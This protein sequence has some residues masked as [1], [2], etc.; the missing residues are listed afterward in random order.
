MESSGIWTTPTIKSQNKILHFEKITINQRFWNIFFQI[1]EMMYWNIFFRQLKY[2]ILML[3]KPV[4]YIKMKL[5]GSSALSCFIWVRM[6]KVEAFWKFS[7]KTF[8][9][10]KT[11]FHPHFLE[12]KQVSFGKFLNLK[13]LYSLRKLGTSCCAGKK[14]VS[15]KCEHF[16]I[17]GGLMFLFG[18]ANRIFQRGN[19]MPCRQ[20]AIADLLELSD[21]IECL[22]SKCWELWGPIDFSAE[23]D[24]NEWD[25]GTD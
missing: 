25:S 8:W 15:S 23:T 6:I 24:H 13:F 5:P 9:S 19:E 2:F 11:L 22:L 16:E 4:Y 20:T 1:L 12:R 17:I 14:F 7:F 3:F 10:C 21:N 18:F